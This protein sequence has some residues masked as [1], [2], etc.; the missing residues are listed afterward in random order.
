M[1]AVHVVDADGDVG[2]RAGQR[3]G[4]DLRDHLAGLLVDLE[5]VPAQVLR[6]RAV[7]GILRVRDE[8]VPGD[9]DGIE[10]RG[11][12][13]AGGRRARRPHH[14]GVE[15]V[16][17]VGVGGQDD[18]LRGH[19]V[20]R[21][22]RVGHADGDGQRVTAVRLLR[23]GGGHRAVLGHG[24]RPALG[25]GVGP[26]AVVGVVA[27][28]AVA[29]GRLVRQS[30]GERRGD[31][32]TGRGHPARVDGV[33]HARGVAVDGDG[34]GRGLLRRAAFV[35]QLHRDVD[36]GTGQRVRGHRRGDLP[37]VLVDR[38]HPVGIG[39]GPVLVRAVGEGVAAR[40]LG[41]RVPVDAVGRH[42]RRQCDL[43]AG[44]AVHALVGG[45][46]HTGDDLE[47][48]GDLVS[49]A[50]RVGRGDH[51]LGHGVVRGVRRG[52]GGDGAVVGDGDLP[53]LGDAGG[54]DRVALRDLRGL[55]PE[56]APQGR[57]GLELLALDADLHGVLD[58][59]GLRIIRVDHRQQRQ[60]VLRAVG[61]GDDD[62]RLGEGARRGAG[63]R[64]DA[65]V[66]VAFV[67]FDELGLPPVVDVVGVQLDR[68]AGAALALGLDQIGDHV[69]DLLEDDLL[70]LRGH[71]VLAD[72]GGDRLLPGLVAWLVVLRVVQ[73]DVRAAQ[74]VRP[75]VAADG[76]NGLFKYVGLLTICGLRDV[77]PENVGSALRGVGGEGDAGVLRPLRVD[78]L[79]QR[80]GDRAVLGDL[81]VSVDE[82]PVVGVGL[83]DDA[84][85]GR[86]VGEVDLADLDRLARFDDDALEVIP[87]HRDR[88]AVGVL[89]GP[90]VH[91]GDRVQVLKELEA[92]AGVVRAV[93]AR[94]AEDEP[95]LACRGC[96][97][98]LLEL[99][100]VAG[101]GLPTV[102]FFV[103]AFLDH[104]AVCIFDRVF[105]SAIDPGV[106]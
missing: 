78:V 47:D 53:S 103:F 24:D 13:G 42:G 52:D 67:R 15:R 88:R 69:A 87:A 11:V 105:Q 60:N 80:V 33:V 30:G 74:D 22:V 56:D 79:R 28:Q 73:A 46:L 75:V 99:Q 98:L 71:A 38:E 104:L 83:D 57:P 14:R 63:G 2:E 7:A 26:V 84:V 1:R 8:G 34:G 5:L 93:F 106:G 64:G 72:A 31:R 61:V 54:V 77:S 70:R 62:A 85:P 101:R 81:R 3:L 45:D 44:F 49:G 100:I 95:L 21:A 48:D 90:R 59:G 35:V 40:F 29:R 96:D 68:R 65:H 20:G 58:V 91:T 94:R 9:T 41:L 36:V 51:R 6:Q 86:G 89:T 27:G 55:L 76:I 4:A 12:D 43:G 19:L 25:A 37:R 102:D 23:R 39:G 97:V 50:V 92:R 66:V 16:V 18:E 10:L 82:A 17:R 32:H